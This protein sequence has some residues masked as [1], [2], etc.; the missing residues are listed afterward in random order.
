[1]TPSTIKYDIVSLKASN[2]VQIM[3]MYSHLDIVS[4]HTSLSTHACT[5]AHRLSP[6]L[7]SFQACATTWWAPPY[8]LL[9]LMHSSMTLRTCTTLAPLSS[10]SSH[11]LVQSRFLLLWLPK[12]LKDDRMEDMG[13]AE[14][15]WCR[16]VMLELN[17]IDEWL[18]VE[19]DTI[20]H[21]LLVERLVSLER[22]RGRGNK[23]PV[24]KHIRLGPC[25]GIR[26]PN[27]TIDHP[28][29]HLNIIWCF[30]GYNIIFYSWEG[31]EVNPWYVR[32]Y[33]PCQQNHLQNHI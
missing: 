21:M 19:N 9:H 32:G 14:R 6:Y 26:C 11:I 2:N 22:E 18:E 13:G 17:A 4:H 33:I 10:D 25:G 23:W 31:H 29:S 20:C 12:K 15:R 5:Q 27:D 30:T 24:C 28:V 16:R 3:V 8:F 1:M 7:N